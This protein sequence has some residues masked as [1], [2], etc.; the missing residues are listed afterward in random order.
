MRPR[1]RASPTTSDAPGPGLS[2]WF[3]VVDELGD[4]IDL[5]FGVVVVGREPEAPVD[6]FVAEV[7][8]RVFEVAQRRVDSRGVEGALE[9]LRL[10]PGDF[11][12]DERAEFGTAVEHAQSMCLEA[13]AKLH[14]EH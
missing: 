13:R 7:V 3:E 1:D 12:C 14:G 2:A 10:P 11:G 6:P 9:R 4:A 8:L 5:F